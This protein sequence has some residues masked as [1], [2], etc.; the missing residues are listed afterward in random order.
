MPTFVQW[1]TYLRQQ[2]LSLHNSCIQLRYHVANQLKWWELYNKLTLYLLQTYADC[3]YYKLTLLVLITNLHYLYF[4]TNLHCT[5]YKLT[6][7]VLITN[8][9]GLYLLQTYADC[10]LLQTYADCTYYKLT[11]LVL[12]TNL[13]WLYL[14]QTYAACTSWCKAVI[15]NGSDS[16]QLWWSIWAR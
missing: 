15:I 2:V 5:Y 1:S 13:C 8:L 4:I 10:T 3:T 16:T 9:H 6:L 7:I 14:L 11:L 12:I